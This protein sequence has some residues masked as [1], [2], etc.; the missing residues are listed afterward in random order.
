MS[1]I[2]KDITPIVEQYL[3]HSCGSCFAA[4]GH[5]CIEY[6]NTTGGYYFPVIDYNKC[7]ECELCYKVCPGDH[8]L[9]PL[10]EKTPTDPF[11]G[12]IISTTVGKA[13]NKKIFLNSQSGG[14]TTA[15][16]KYLLETKQIQA[17]IVTTMDMNS[18]SY[19]KAKIVTTVEELISAQKSKY[20]PTSI[21][22][23]MPEVLKIDGT[24]AMV[25]LSCH[26]H[27]LENLL[28]IKKKLKN[29][30]IKIG[31]VCDRVMTNRSVDFI[32]QQEKFSNVKDFRFR[33][34][35][36]TNYPGDITFVNQNN[37]LKKI[38][39]KKRMLMKDFFTPVRCLLCFD[40][41][42]IYS[43]IVIG[44]PHGIANIDRIN[45]ESLVITRTQLGESIVNEAIK[46]LDIKLRD[47]SLEKAI[48]GQ[49][50]PAKRK[51]WNANIMAWKELEYDMPDYP[52]EV[53][54][55]S[56]EASIL[57]VEKAK[58][59]ILHS[60]SLDRYDTKGALISDANNKYNQLN[61]Q[62]N[63]KYFFSIPK[64]LNQKIKSFVLKKD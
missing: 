48:V 58:K 15:I 45:G 8:F 26:M 60:L 30:I 54:N 42:N 19:T 63:F 41:M 32:I 7:T 12:E 36:N 31:L 51:K 35:S 24:I 47:T 20:I 46:S 55:S 6:K 40:K 1:N 64:K 18:E 9:E 34:T 10:K 39:K 49:S 61:R 27:G 13:T 59:Q 2:K 16:L 11:V 53:L 50:I 28:T 3:C 62:N 14:V 25:G 33:D 21:N 57:D 44:D 17:A 38:N 5:D 23:L 56:I 4:C 22:E 43:D 37:N 29:K 52:A